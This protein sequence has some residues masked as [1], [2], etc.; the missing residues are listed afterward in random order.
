MLDF[1]ECR[2][3]YDAAEVLKGQTGALQ[4][5]TAFF[6]RP[7]NSDWHTFDSRGRL[8]GGGLLDTTLVKAVRKISDKIVQRLMPDGGAWAQIVIE[9]GRRQQM[10]PEERHQWDVALE[11]V[12]MVVQR[13]LGRSNIRKVVSEATRD[14]MALG[15]S[16]A[17][18]II[19]NDG[20]ISFNYIPAN[21]ILLEDS[22]NMAAGGAFWRR[23]MTIRDWKRRYPDFPAPGGKDEQLF[24]AIFG[25][26]P[27]KHGGYEFAFDEGGRDFLFRMPRFPHERA[28]VVASA[29]VAGDETYGI[30]HAGEMLPEAQTLHATRSDQLRAQKLWAN[31]MFV[32]SKA[33]QGQNIPVQPGARIPVNA[34]TLENN[35]MPIRP[36]EVGGSP[37][38][39]FQA[40]ADSQQKIRENMGLMPEAANPGQTVRSATEWIIAEMEARGDLDGIMFEVRD[41]FVQPLLKQSIE[42][43]RRAGNL[44]PRL[45]VDGEF[46]NLEIVGDSEK[47]NKLNTLQKINAFV[48][49]ME[50]LRAVG[51][52]VHTMRLARMTAEALD[53][54]SAIFSPEEMAAAQEAAQAAQGGGQ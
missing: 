47:R 25:W 23:R 2:E 40:I 44:D 54:A 42:L 3:R 45:I 30:G 43:N 8:R 41:E 21:K 15:L 52:P 17:M 50:R 53:L 28:I 36:L 35:S 9:E 1:K 22:P 27:T 37:G 46:F 20:Q 13:G 48:E 51:A 26:L 5:T 4:R 34:D 14:F 6:A 7:L 32:V 18:P 39:A 11:M 49:T 38:V 31:P 16:G 24:T 12:S 10:A 29:Q 19:R 33:I